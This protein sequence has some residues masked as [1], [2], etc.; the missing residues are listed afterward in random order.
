M[1]EILDNLTSQ[2]DEMDMDEDYIPKER[3]N[4]NQNIPDL[5][6]SNTISLYHYTRFNTYK[7]QNIRTF[8]GDINDS[9]YQQII[10]N[11]DSYDFDQVSGLSCYFEINENDDENMKKYLRLLEMIFSRLKNLKTLNIKIKNN[12]LFEKYWQN[13]DKNT[14]DLTYDDILEDQD[15][16][17]FSILQSLR[18]SVNE[19]HELRFEFE[20]IDDSEKYHE[21]MIVNTNFLSKEYFINLNK[22]SLINCGISTLDDLDF[23]YSFIQ[24]DNKFITPCRELI[25]HNNNL[26]YLQMKKNGVRKY[27]TAIN[28]ITGEKHMDIMATKGAERFQ[29]FGYVVKGFSCKDED[30][31]AVNY[32]YIQKF[33]NI[34][35]LFNFYI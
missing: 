4:E 18:H 6:Y 35:T 17:D 27:F 9:N 22:I 2:M 11:I 10:D 34:S 21:L 32:E 30:D 3:R 25:I 31:K 12:N 14:G 29:S 13:I 20:C 24:A 7:E 26:N 19:L 1:A 33:R 28:P 5:T 8:L 16:F 23:Y 15:Y